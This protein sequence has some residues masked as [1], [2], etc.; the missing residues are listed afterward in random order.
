MIAAYIR[1]STAE[2]AKEGYSIGEQQER[3][4]AFCKAHGWG[5]PKMFTDAG[6]SGGNTNRPALQELVKEIKAGSISRVVVYKLDRLSRSQKDTLELLEDVFLPNNVDFISMSENFDTGS[7]FGKATIGLF[8][9]FA[10]LE[11]EQIKER[12]MVGREARAKE[13]KYH[14]GHTPPV[15][16]DYINGEL[17]VNEFEA[18]QVRECF[19]LYLA[20]HT[21][22]EIAFEL[23]K[24]GW[25]HKY[26]QWI[27]NRVRDVL[28]NPIYIGTISFSGVRYKGKHEALIDEETFETVQEMIKKK[29]KKQTS[30]KRP[31]F[32]AYLVGKIW[33]A[34]CGARYCHTVSYSG[35]TRTG[36]RLSYYACYSRANCNKSMIRDRN[37]PNT[38]HR[39]DK[40]DKIIFDELRGLKL[41]DVRSYRRTLEEHDTIKPLQKELSKIEKQRSRLID[42]YALGSFSPEELNAKIEPLNASKKAIEEQLA[43]LSTQRR[44]MDEM[45]TIVDSI[46]GILD[47]GEPVH[48]RRLIETLVDRV[49]IDGDDITI[50]WDFD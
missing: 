16:Y 33:C 23:N 22:T 37:C 20:G 25:H 50:F 6:Y 39:A 42:L 21:Y 31:I 12:V 15:G 9:V 17:V 36:K 40:I 48:I 44:S 49:E 19:K 2:Q 24:R 34:K 18:M 35:H 14:G 8:S 3:L 43:S 13:G 41:G 28:K 38:I 7:P 4:T 27:L 45:K 30:V 29:H 11:R 32:E 5:L 47:A 1:V 26:G 46:G 10:Q